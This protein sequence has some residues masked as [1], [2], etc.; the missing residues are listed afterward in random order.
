MFN[1][2]LAGRIGGER[3]IL[4]GDAGSSGVSAL[5]GGLFFGGWT[6]KVM[7]GMSLLYAVNQ[8]F[9][10]FAALSVV[11][12]NAPWFHV[13]ERGV[14]GGVFGIMISSGYFLAMTVGGW[15][16]AYLPWYCVFL[17]PSA[18]LAVMG[19]VDRVL[20]A[21]ASLWQAD[22]GF[23]PADASSQTPDNDTPV[24]LAYLVANVF[25]NRII[26]TLMAAE[27]CTGF[28]RQGL[29][30]WFVPFLKEVH[31]VNHGTALF[32]VATGGITVGGILG[33]LLCGW[34]SDHVFG[35]RRPPVAFVFYIGQILSLL[36]LGWVTSA[37]AASFMIGFTC[38]WIF[39]VHGMLSGTASM[40]FGGTRA[41]ATVTGLLDGIQYVAAGLTGVFL[42]HFLD[43]WGWSAWTWMIIP[44]SIIGGCLM[45]TLWDATPQNTRVTLKAPE[46]AGAA[47]EETPEPVAA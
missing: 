31:H 25:T 1:G 32:T 16:L 13:R 3:A 35:S 17:I 7:V 36:V 4:I 15:I 14:F 22:P 30:L 24:G 43:R 12:T 38:M 19:L 37:G 5:V 10:S 2:P 42:G 9:Q 20:V 28:V 45:L 11:K 39:G 27:L 46:P 21:D 8:Y 41:A 6:A 34:L 47:S 40:D 44:L 29:L 23:H 18:V 26:L 33:G